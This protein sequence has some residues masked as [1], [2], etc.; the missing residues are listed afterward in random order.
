MGRQ[1]MSTL[2]ENSHNHQ[3]QTRE[4]LRAQHGDHF[5]KFERV[6]RELDMLSHELHATSEH[7]VQLDTA[8]DVVCRGGSW[9]LT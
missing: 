1:N 3:E 9:E 5:D 4:E 2:C 8:R 6:I 7:A